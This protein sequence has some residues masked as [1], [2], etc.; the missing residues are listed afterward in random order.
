MPPDPLEPILAQADTGP[1]PLR[2][3]DLEAVARVV[4]RLDPE[5]FIQ[6]AVQAPS[7]SWDDGRA[8]PPDF[9]EVH[10][11][12][13]SIDVSGRGNREHLVVIAA[14]AALVDELDLSYG[15]DWVA[16]VLPRAL[17]VEPVAPGD[18]GLTFRFRRLV[19]AAPLGDLAEFVH[20]ADYGE[21]LHAIEQAAAPPAGVI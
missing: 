4:T 16:R 20:P 6:A 7:L 2:R 13:W 1:G 9:F 5:E 18:A 3:R 8:R 21:F 11:D 12:R 10:G 14:A 15:I 19:P 17:V